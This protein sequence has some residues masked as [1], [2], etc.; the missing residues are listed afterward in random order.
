M[1]KLPKVIKSDF[2]IVDI[3][4]GRKKLAEHFKDRPFAG[5]CPAAFRVPVVLTG[6][7]S[8]VWGHDDGESRE[9]SMV[10]EKVTLED[11]GQ[12]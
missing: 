4:R 7:L 6:Y 2:A 10:V 1:S 3:Q 5:P 9:F 11:G 8:D 12:S